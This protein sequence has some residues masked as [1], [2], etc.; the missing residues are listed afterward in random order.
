M[1]TRTGKSTEVIRKVVVEKG[2]FEAV[3]EDG[4]HVRVEAVAPSIL[5]VRIAPGGK[6]FVSGLERYGFLKVDTGAVAAK[7][8]RSRDSV[9]LSAGRVCA[10][11]DRRSGRLSF[12]GPSGKTV[13]AEARRAEVGAEG[14]FRTSF[15]LGAG[16]EFVGLGDQTR[17]RLRQR[18]HTAT[19]WVTNVTAY[20]PVPLVMSTRKYGVFLNTTFLHWWDMGEK[21]GR[22]WGF[23]GHGGGLDYFVIAGENFGELLDHYTEITGKPQ[24]PPRWSFGLWFIANQW[25]N[26][27]GV[28]DDCNRFRSLGIPC[29]VFGLEPGWMS[30]YYDYSTEK[31]WDPKRFE[32]PPWAPNGP[33][34]F[35][36]AMK[37][38]G[39]KLMLWLCQNYDLSEH[40]EAKLAGGS[41]GKEGGGQTS[42]A[43]LEG[44]DVLNQEATRIDPL[45]KPGEPWFEHLK[46]FIDQGAELFKQDGSVQVLPHPDRKWANG[47]DDEEMHNL[48]P[49]LYSRQMYEGFREHTGRR[50]TGFTVDGWAG[51]QRWTGTW[52]GDTGGGPKPLVSMLQNSLVGHGLVTCDM[53]VTTPEGIHFGF[54]QPWAQ[55]NSWGYWR[56]P[57]Y[58]G[59]RLEG[60]IREYAKLR[61]RMLPYLYSCAHEARLTGMPMLRA[62]P[63][64]FGD[65]T[66]SF[67]CLHEYML[68]P[69]LLVAAFEKRLYLPA[70]GWID[71][72]TGD[73]HKGPRESVY[74]PPEGRGGALMLRA[75]GIVPLGPS[76]EYVGDRTENE[77][78]IEVASGADG[79]FTLYEDDGVSYEY[80]K[81][82]VAT[83][84]IKL[85]D[86]GG[87]SV[88]RVGR[89]E[90]SFAG[91]G[92]PPVIRLKVRSTRGLARVRLDGE[93]LQAVSE[94]S[95]LGAGGTGYAYDPSDQSLWIGC[96]TAPFICEINWKG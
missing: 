64:V 52:A 68:G 53:E 9:T 71:Y 10:R 66:K 39:F 19:M 33:H 2:A 30:K 78:V 17:E 91:M 14:G 34:T 87:R 67:D 4:V 49:L 86:S 29:D 59:K 60:V 73:S 26:A 70:G 25:D 55:I 75:G 63:L 51:F 27:R 18:G 12:A 77:L 15:A 76:M 32:I 36:S 42:G 1:A 41:A 43:R 80:E 22:R 65:E 5:R 23:H 6:Y 56:H 81:G 44:D 93:A 48:Y 95:A 45:T 90:G 8:V 85:S 89:R 31:G 37:R 84:R 82:A 3:R 58:Q 11:L 94:A 46:K 21:D 72:W 35:A 20:V 92:E 96:A 47:M 24:M 50:A 62:L 83:M 57:W 16:E 40:E 28:L 79:A 54:L 88:I 74:A 61:Y 13:L 69:A 38:M 7:T